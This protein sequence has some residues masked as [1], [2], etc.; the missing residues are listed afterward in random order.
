MHLTRKPVVTVGSTVQPTLCPIPTPSPCSES[1]MGGVLQNTFTCHH[2][3]KKK[4]AR[5]MSA[6]IR[7]PSWPVKLHMDSHTRPFTTRPLWFRLGGRRAYH[8]AVIRWATSDVSCLA[9]IPKLED[10]RELCNRRWEEGGMERV[11]VTFAT[12]YKA[13]AYIVWVYYHGCSVLRRWW[14]WWWH[15]VSSPLPGR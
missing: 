5:D 3:T 7:Q 13:T 4:A 14:W 9:D 1:A 12:D 2:T 8:A 10:D 11:P 6:G 15:A